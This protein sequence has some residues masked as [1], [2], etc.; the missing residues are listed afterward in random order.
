MEKTNINPHASPKKRYVWVDYAKF[1]S[2]LLVVSYHTPQRAGGYV[3]DL[4]YFL[5]MPAFFMMAGF[6][7]NADRFPSLGHFLKHRSIQLIVPY[8]SFFTIF[9]VSWLLFGRNWVG[10]NELSIPL[11]RPL[12]EFAYGSPTT[13]VAPYWFICCLF[14]MQIIYYLLIRY[15]PKPAVIA[16]VFVCP[17][18]NCI[19]GTS[20]LPWNLSAALLY[21]PFYAFP[22][23][24]KEYIKS[25]SSKNVFGALASLCMALFLIR[26][27]NRGNALAKNMEVE[28]CGLLIM[29]AYTIFIKALSRIKI[30]DKF[31]AFIGKNTIIILALHNYIIGFFKIFLKD[32]TNHE[33][34]ATNMTFTI[35][36]IVICCLPIK[37]INSYAPFLIG[38][39]PCFEKKLK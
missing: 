16:V 13:V 26:Y 9:Y 5:R 6:L 2:I 32:M 4:L 35:L 28:I 25:L 27:G 17:L 24:Y 18:L 14:S 37:L 34:Y 20:Y 23:I 12:I 29:P 1:F 10:E 11:W 8:V 36:T 19:P 31:V 33:G 21:I 30:T 38:R 7:F 39:G 15:L 3:G 22:N